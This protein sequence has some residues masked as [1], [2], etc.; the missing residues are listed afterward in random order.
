MWS[1]TA[2]AILEDGQRSYIV[3]PGDTVTPGTAVVAI[4]VR[5]EVLRL[6]RGGTLVELKLVDVRRTP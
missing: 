1:D 2:L 6:D 5:R 4:D 3:G